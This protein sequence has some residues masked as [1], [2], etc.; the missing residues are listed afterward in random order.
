VLVRESEH[1]PN[2]SNMHVLKVLDEL[3]D[4]RIEVVGCVSSFLF[5]LLDEIKM[6]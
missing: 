3:C 6:E 2:S 5:N 4:T 1:T